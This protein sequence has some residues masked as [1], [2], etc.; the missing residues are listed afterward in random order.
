MERFLRNSYDDIPPLTERIFKTQQSFVNP[1]P[2]S[3]T[4]T[5]ASLR[6]QSYKQYSQE[7]MTRAIKAVNE[8]MSVRRAALEYNVPKTTLNDRIQGK[9]V[10]GSSSGKAKYLSDEEE[11]ELVRF[12][13]RSASI[14]YSRSRTEVIAIVQRVCSS[15]GLDVTVTHGWWEAFCRRHPSI[16]LRKPAHLALSRAKSSDPESLSYYFDLLEKTLTEY[17]LL[18]KPSQIFNIDE[19]GVPLNPDASKSIFKRGAKNP[20]MI[21]SGD[22]SQVTVVGCVSAAGYCIPPM[23]IWD[24]KT[25][26][27]DMAEGELPG[28]IYGFSSKGWIDQELFHIWFECHF[29]RYAPPVRPLLLLMDGHSSHFCPDT[30]RMASKEEVVLFTL[31]PNTTHLSQP[32]DKGCFAPLKNEWKKVCHDFLVREH[33]VVTRYTFNKLFS[34]AWM[35]SMTIKNILAGF[36]VSGIYP[37]DRSKLLVDKADIKPLEEMKFNPLITP[38]THIKHDSKF[39]PCIF[40]DKEMNDFHCQYPTAA[41]DTDTDENSEQYVKWKEMYRPYT[42]V[43]V[44]EN[45]ELESPLNCSL[46]HTPTKTNT[47]VVMVAQRGRPLRSILKYPSPITKVVHREQKSTSRVLTSAENLKI[48]EEKQKMKD[49][50]QRQKEERQKQKEERQR[51]KEMAK[52]T[53]IQNNIVLVKIEF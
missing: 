15:K 11:E 36:R 29:L 18:D 43:P 16:A 6:P 45:D 25:L 7:V 12:L 53:S 37:L 40:S 50:K 1:P 8:G 39:S 32:L 42:V 31:P 10:H 52:Q 20:V 41:V 44:C 49:E 38:V 27:P 46:F 26:H 47:D 4:T 51:L 9:V 24:R 3:Y 28:T 48:L 22:K 35:K 2:S 23:I 19:T 33:K 5:V 14:G 13:M 30:I 34:Q 17:N 21:T